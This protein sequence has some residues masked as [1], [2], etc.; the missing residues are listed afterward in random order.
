[1]ADRVSVEINAREFSRM[2]EELAAIDPRVEFRDVI[3]GIAERVVAG[4]LRKT[5][6]ANAAK[7]RANYNAKEYTTFNGK[8]YRLA[9]RYP[10]P[11]WRQIDA[12]ETARLE[13]RLAARGLSKKS[14]L[15]V[16]RSFGGNVGNAAPGYVAAANSKGREF[17]GNGKSV[18][19]G[20][21]AGFTLEIMNYSPIVQRAGGYF[22]L[23]D[24]MRGEVMYFRRNMENR[25]FAT[26]ESR[27]KKYPQIFMRKTA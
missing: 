3:L 5:K 11:L 8:V 27:A 14:W 25:A 7:I 18:E 16:A 24:A 23:Q 21:A 4:A 6:A 9:N 26:F 22:A 17:V 1:M 2:I 12:A 13:T 15:H 10:D 19:K 20:T